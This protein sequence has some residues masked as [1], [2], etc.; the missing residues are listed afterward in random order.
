MLRADNSPGTHT[1]RPIETLSGSHRGTR[2]SHEQGEG[3]C[4]QARTNSSQSLKGRE[5]EYECG[6]MAPEENG[7]CGSERKSEIFN[8]KTEPSDEQE[9]HGRDGKNPQNEG[10]G[11]RRRHVSEYSREA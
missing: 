3:D 5:T 1:G 6:K 11:W 10:A 2:P 9:N 7:H 4:C 8:G